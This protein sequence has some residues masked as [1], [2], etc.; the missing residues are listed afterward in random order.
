[1]HKN[2]TSC[3]SSIAY[4]AIGIREHVGKASR[5]A[6]DPG[7]EPRR[8]DARPLRR[9][10]HGH[11]L[12]VDQRTRLLRIARNEKPDARRGVGEL[13]PRHHVAVRFE[14]LDDVLA[15]SGQRGDLAPAAALTDEV[16]RRPA[17]IL[18][19]RDGW[20]TV[21]ETGELVVALA[22]GRV[23][24]GRP[25]CVR[26]GLRGIPPLRRARRCSSLLS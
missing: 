11:R 24:G 21:H 22:A 7:G 8:G 9:R 19:N 3:A 4:R 23:R 6:G 20:F 12:A 1:M 18:R 26:I 15:E 5:T 2:E 13:L 10:E 16:R 17:L 14:H 25:G